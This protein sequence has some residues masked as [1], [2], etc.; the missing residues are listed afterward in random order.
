M[1]TSCKEQLRSMTTSIKRPLFSGP[2]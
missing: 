2:W 1:T